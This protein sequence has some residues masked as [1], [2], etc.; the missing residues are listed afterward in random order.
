MLRKKIRPYNFWG[1]PDILSLRMDPYPS[2]KIVGL[3]VKTSHP[4]NRI[5]GLILFLGHAN[6]SLGYLSS[7]WFPTCFFFTPDPWGRFS[8]WLTSF[9]ALTSLIW[10][11]VKGQGDVGP[12]WTSLRCAVFHAVPGK[13]S[14][15]FLRQ[16]LLVLGVKLPKK[17]GHLAF[18]VVV[19][20]FD[21]GKRFCC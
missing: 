13:P 18:Q 12:F 7:W 9:V 14:A 6:G 15:L 16:K 8:F 5:V 21:R 2:R 10:K 17:L 19:V 11:V 4:H 3:M 20:F 1:Q